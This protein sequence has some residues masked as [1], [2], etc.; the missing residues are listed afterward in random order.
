MDIVTDAAVNALSR[1]L[2]AT[3][4]KIWQR[5]C[6]ARACLE[7]FEREKSSNQ[8]KYAY[9]QRVYQQHA[10]I[11]VSEFKNLI[12]VGLDA[13]ILCQAKLKQVNSQLTGKQIWETIWDSINSSMVNIIIPTWLQVGPYNSDGTVKSGVQNMEE[14]YLKLRVA[15]FNQQKNSINLIKEKLNGDSAGDLE[16][17][18]EDEN[19][20]PTINALPNGTN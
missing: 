4:L 19:E 1:K 18:D 9:A 6:A 14:Y 3:T 16:E 13:N 11:I 5:L 10:S 20:E 8:D 15:L 12:P 7:T 17:E 2:D